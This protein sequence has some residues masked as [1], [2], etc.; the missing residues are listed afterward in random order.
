MGTQ[1]LCW[2]LINKFV[3]KKVA[4]ALREGAW[5]GTGDANQDT[6]LPSLTWN[7]QALGVSREGCGHSGLAQITEGSL[8]APVCL[9]LD[10]ILQVTPFES[11]P[12]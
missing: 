12:S 6:A 9:T 11:L 5:G 3:S 4:R 2:V 8:L 1:F 7:S 10:Q